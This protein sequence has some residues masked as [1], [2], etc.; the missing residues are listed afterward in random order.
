MCRDN[1]CLNEALRDPYNLISS[2]YY[3]GRNPRVTAID[4]RQAVRSTNNIPQTCGGRRLWSGRGG[5]DI[6][7]LHGQRCFPWSKRQEFRE[8]VDQH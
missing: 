3:R 2:L 5:N 7:L 4:L 1:P 8:H 6:W